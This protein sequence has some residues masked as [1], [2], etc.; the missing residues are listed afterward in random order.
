MLCGRACMRVRA[1]LRDCDELFVYLPTLNTVYGQSH[2]PHKTVSSVSRRQVSLLA[3]PKTPIYNPSNPHSPSNSLLA[4]R[5]FSLPESF[6]SFNAALA[7]PITSFTRAFSARQSCIDAARN[8]AQ[9]GTSFHHQKKTTHTLLTLTDNS[10]V[11]KQIT[12]NA[13]TRAKHRDTTKVES[14]FTRG[15]QTFCK[16]AQG[17]R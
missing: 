9:I 17:H 15:A 14:Y 5:I 6:P 8:T 16:N 1:W 13:C 11:Q 7:G 2:G 10:T 3:V 12:S 4:T